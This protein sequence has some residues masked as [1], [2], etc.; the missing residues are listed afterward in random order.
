MIYRV[1][2][3]LFLVGSLHAEPFVYGGGL[4]KSNKQIERNKSSIYKLKQ[5]T[6]RLRE[7]I[8]GLRSI[9]EGLNNTIRKLQQQ[10]NPNNSAAINDMASLLDKINQN[11]VSKE[12]M[13]KALKVSTSNSTTKRKTAQKA[14]EAKKPSKE[15][16]L[17]GASSSALY[18]KGVR[19]VNKKRYT[20]AKKRFD[21][22]SERGYKKASTY[23]YLGEIAYRTGKYSR[24][25]EEY[26]KSA[27][28]DEYAGY[29]DKLLLHTG[30]SLEKNGD[31]AQAKRFFQAIIDGYP[32]TTSAKI[33]KKHI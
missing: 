28:L 5:E 2:L 10:K 19:L 6:S 20:D 1:V 16:G 11:Y 12:E 23:F 13:R 27:E 25:V 18:S 24:A 29:M 31:K 26:K 7:E 32:E 22:L 9:V 4:S 21:I 33:A 8:E 3:A 30:L 15:G 14:S 17:A